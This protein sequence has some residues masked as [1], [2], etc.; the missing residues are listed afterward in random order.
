MGEKGQSD[1]TE[2]EHVG[3][4]SEAGDVPVF[5]WS[6]GF[7]GV[8]VLMFCNLHVFSLMKYY[9]IKNWEW[10]ELE[11]SS[12]DNNLGSCFYEKEQ[13]NIVEVGF[14]KGVLKTE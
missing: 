12:P 13:K 2:E 4:C 6:R 9:M 14:R 8:Q 5:K 11:T 10:D 3:W 7:I 1:S